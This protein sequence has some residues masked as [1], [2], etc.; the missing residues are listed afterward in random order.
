MDVS[1]TKFEDEFTAVQTPAEGH[2]P[3]STT[4]EELKSNSL[5]YHQSRETCL[6]MT[7]DENS[8]QVTQT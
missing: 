5:A 1:N 6:V 8:P 7:G 3:S 2:A 4:E